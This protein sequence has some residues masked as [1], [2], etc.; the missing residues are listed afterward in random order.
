MRGWRVGWWGHPWLLFRGWDWPVEHGGRGRA[1][2]LLG[3]AL[4]LGALAAQCPPT[5]SPCPVQGLQS[6]GTL[7]RCMSLVHQVPGS[8]VLEV[9]ESWV[10]GA[11][12]WDLCP[13]TVPTLFQWYGLLARTHSSSSTSRSVSDL[14]PRCP[15]PTAHS[16]SR[17]AHCPL[18]ATLGPR[19]QGTRAPK[20]QKHL[21]L[22]GHPSPLRAFCRILSVVSQSARTD[23]PTDE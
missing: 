6:P 12:C 1:E 18:A 17:A 5:T 13:R 19:N 7:V 8:W 9:L 4:V 11:G 21:R 3:P 22:P 16:H 20:R 2:S 23:E 14:H 15:L 10:M